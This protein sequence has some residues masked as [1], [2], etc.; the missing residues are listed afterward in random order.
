MLL[1]SKPQYNIN[2]DKHCLNSSRLFVITICLTLYFFLSVSK[3]RV[4]FFIP[5]SCLGTALIHYVSISPIYTAV[6]H[7]TKN[8]FPMYW[9]EKCNSCGF[10][11]VSILK[12]FQECSIRR[13]IKYLHSSVI[14]SFFDSFIQMA[15]WSSSFAFSN[16]EYC[17]DEG[18]EDFNFS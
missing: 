4:Y 2:R 18:F 9:I 13:K 6:Q 14:I 11:P 15:V 12:I 3:S 8:N 10:Y 16:V 1:F 7:N 17:T 5:S